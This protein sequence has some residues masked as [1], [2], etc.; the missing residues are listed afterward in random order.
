MLVKLDDLQLS[1]CL[2]PFEFADFSQFSFE[3]LRQADL[4]HIWNLVDEG[5]LYFDDAPG[6]VEKN[7][8]GFTSKFFPLLK[9]IGKQLSV[10]VPFKFD[11]LM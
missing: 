8:D 10:S 9:V 3:R 4:E 2:I 6:R 7:F 11:S 5:K 1:E